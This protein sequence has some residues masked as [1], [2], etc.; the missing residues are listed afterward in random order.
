MVIAAAVPSTEMDPFFAAFRIPDLIFQLV[1][2]GAL[3]SALIPVVSELFTTNE[4]TRAWRVVSTVINLMLLGL[5][6]LAAALFVLAPVVVPIITPGFDGPKLDKTIELTR[7][8]LLSPIFL[9]MGAVATSVLN[10]GGRFAASAIAPVV[11]NL[12]IIGGALLLGPSLGIDGL[13]LSVVAGSLGHLLVQL[14]P[15]TRM[16]FRYDARI[17]AGDPE[18][19]KA[20]FLMAPR[21]LG[22]GVTQVT[23]IVVTALASLLGN[24]AVSDFNFAFAL[25]QIP[26]GIIGV[27]L[28]IV[29]LPTLSREAAVGNE[30]SFA[31]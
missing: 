25:L 26:L 23:F 31:A 21:A 1:A 13:A 9:A 27:P 18:A 11:Y 28:G 15:L 5:L 12:A 2:A 20:L 3:S 4:R 19:R 10:A 29:V 16:G 6:A 7:I 24:G 22:L 17:E 30:A 8:M 14:R